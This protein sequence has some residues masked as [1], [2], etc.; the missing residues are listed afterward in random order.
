MGEITAEFLGAGIHS[1]LGNGV[2]ANLAGLKKLPTAPYIQK[3]TVTN[4]TIDIPYKLLAQAPLENISER[5]YGVILD[6]IEQALNEAQLNAEQRQHV[7]LF[8]GS[9]SFD[10]SAI[11]ALYQQ[12]LEQKLQHSDTAIPL[13]NPSFA[14]LAD[15]LIHALD[16]RGEDYSFNTACT[17]SANALIAA[18]AQV[19]AGFIDHALVLA[20]ELHNDVTAL[21]FHSLNLLTA[22][23]MKPFDVKRDGLVLGEGVSALLIGKAPNDGK[24]R[25]HLCGS[26][27]ISDTHSITSTNPDGSM[28]HKVIDD[29]L[30]DAKVGFDEISAIKI[31]GTASLRNDESEAAGMHQSFENLPPLCA[32]KPFIGHTLGACGLNELI[33]FYKAIEAGFLIATP[34][35][36]VEE[37]DLNVQLNQQ[38]SAVNS[39]NFMLNYFGFGGN[40]TSLV[41]SNLVPGAAS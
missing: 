1:S 32:I 4:E 17:S 23:V 41:I 25:F 3:N 30:A 19:E 22:S 21:G 6:V 10:I 29:A 34:G 24:P 38:R 20:L 35:I 8:I 27:S 40:N 7:G 12:E 2:G 37:G 36:G 13:R 26:A 5:I 9:S 18:T 28:V 39:G 15:Y 33:L 11:E 16:L 14:N 31:H